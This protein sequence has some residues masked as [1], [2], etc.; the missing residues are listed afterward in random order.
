[1]Q[2]KYLIAGGAATLILLL[3]LLFSGGESTAET[4]MSE[5]V[6]SLAMEE[7]HDEFGI[8][9]DGQHVVKGK[10]RP[11]EFLADILLPFGISYAQITTLAEKSKSV[12]DIRKLMAGKNYTLICTNDSAQRVEFFVYE[13]SAVDFVVFDL[14]DT[15]SIYRGNRPTSIEEQMASG[16]IHSSLYQTLIDQDLS[17]ALAMEMADIYAWS[18][19]FY[20]IQKGDRFKLIYTVKKVN[21]EIVGIDEIQAAVFYHYD[22]PFYA[23]EFAQGDQTDYFDETGNSLRKAFLQ[24]PLKFSRIS[25]GYTKSRFHPVQKRWKAHLGTDYAAPQGTPILSVGDGIVTEAQYKQFNGNYVKVKHNSTYTTQYLHMSKIASGIKPGT[26][27]KQGQV[28]G[29]VGSTGL[30]TGPHVCFRFWKNGEQ[31]DH[32]REKIPPSEP[33]KPEYK[34]EYENHLREWKSRLDD[35]PMETKVS[36]ANLASMNAA[37]RL[38]FSHT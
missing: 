36:E 15:I 16:V 19:D 32:R 6:D 31:V 10:I 28:I 30:A 23:F 4:E 25:S 13:A 14:R 12:F 33:I 18:I 35:I 21:E 11:N 26:R 24:A 9:A 27:V 8:D 29:Y 3:I 17:P 38:N 34:Q 1:M 20:R 5:E 2:K 37:N 7:C 22:S